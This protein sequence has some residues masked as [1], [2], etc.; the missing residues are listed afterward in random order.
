L[1]EARLQLADAALATANPG[2]FDLSIKLMQAD[3]AALP[4]STIA[5]REKWREVREIQRPGVLPALSA[6]TRSSLLKDIA[7]R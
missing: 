7:H 1:F 4:E 3:I 2:A 6:A 5:V